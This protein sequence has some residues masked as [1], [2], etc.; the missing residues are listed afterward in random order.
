MNNDFHRTLFT[1]V[2]NKSHV[3]FK[4]GGAKNDYNDFRIDVSVQEPDFTQKKL[5][6][7]DLRPK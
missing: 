6:K 1:E 4:S 3:C 2:S 7:G 5:V